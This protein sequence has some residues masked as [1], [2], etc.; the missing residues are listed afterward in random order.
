STTSTGGN[1]RRG[2]GTGW[3]RLGP[4]S[5]DGEAR[6]PQTGSVSTRR[7]S[8]SISTVEWPSQVARSPL[9][10]G[11]DHVSSGLID[12]SAPRGTRRSPPQRNSPIVGMDAFGSRRPAAIGYML[13]N[14]SPAQSG[15]ALMRSRRAPSDLLPRDFMRLGLQR[16]SLATT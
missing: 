13:R 11:F 7:P 10:G 16:T 12:G 3:K 4:A 2:T 6:G 15:E 9:S 8:I 1:A 14:R 5:R